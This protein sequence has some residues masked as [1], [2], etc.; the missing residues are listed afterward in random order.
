MFIDWHVRLKCYCF[1]KIPNFFYDFL[2]TS[3][4]FSHTH[5]THVDNWGANAE[6]GR[7]D[8][9]KKCW[10]WQN[11]WRQKAVKRKPRKSFKPAKKNNKD[12]C[13]GY[14]WNHVDKRAQKELRNLLAGLL[15]KFLSSPFSLRLISLSI[16]PQFIISCRTQKGPNYSR[17]NKIKVDE[18]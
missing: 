17:Q 18:L 6:G 8:A 12:K 14:N 13:P 15:E 1:S 3:I 9:A 5:D 16:K 7:N 11:Q 4:P 10:V 2:P